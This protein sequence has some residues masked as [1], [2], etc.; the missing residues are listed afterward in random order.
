VD[1]CELSAARRSAKLVVGCAA[2]IWG[3]STVRACQAE[4]LL[5]LALMQSMEYLSSSSAG[6]HARSARK[7]RY[8][9]AWKLRASNASSLHA[10]AAVREGTLLGL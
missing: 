8:A 6:T 7:R 10:H 3:S 4:K 5:K 9:H 1:G 2:W